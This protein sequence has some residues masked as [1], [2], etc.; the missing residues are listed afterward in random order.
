METGY[1]RNRI[2]LDL[3]LSGTTE[4]YASVNSDNHV[5][6]ILKIVYTPK[7]LEYV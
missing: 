2:Y 1:R 3:A 7:V 6:G 4:M 5:R